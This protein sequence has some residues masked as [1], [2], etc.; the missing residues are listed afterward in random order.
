VPSD[1]TG[2]AIG[3]G[4]GVALARYP[5]LPALALLEPCR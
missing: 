3:D 1:T 4:V 5:Q 2:P